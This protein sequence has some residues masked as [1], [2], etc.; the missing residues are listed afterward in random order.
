[1]YKIIENILLTML[2]LSLGTCFASTFIGINTGYDICKTIALYGLTFAIF[3]GC[4]AFI[5]YIWKK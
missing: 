2:V 1:M 3:F 5:H 4:L